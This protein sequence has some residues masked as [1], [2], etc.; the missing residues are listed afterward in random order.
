[1][2]VAALIVC[3]LFAWLVYVS[4][5]AALFAIVVVAALLAGVVIGF[6]RA[7]RPRGR[8]RGIVRTGEGGPR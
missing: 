1:M 5:R 3:A 8:Y 2:I 4:V 6:E 7:L